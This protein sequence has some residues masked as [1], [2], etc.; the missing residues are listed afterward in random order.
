MAKT[1]EKNE[2]TPEL[3]VDEAAELRTERD[4]AVEGREILQQA[5]DWMGANHALVVWQKNGRGQTS[6]RIRLDDLQVEQDYTDPIEGFLEALGL[7]QARLA[8]RK[9]NLGIGL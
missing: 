3:F 8:R 4:Q 5:L 7:M 2:D 6:V 9:I 1:K